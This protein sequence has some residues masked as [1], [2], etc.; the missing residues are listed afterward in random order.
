MLAPRPRVLLLD[1]PFR[2]LDAEVRQKLRADTKRWQRDLGIPTILVTDDR[3]EAL[4]LGD[5]VAIMNGGRFEQIDTPQNVYARPATEFVGRFIDRANVFLTDLSESYGRLVDMRLEMIDHPE[6]ISMFSWEGEQP[7]EEG[8]APIVDCAF[9]GCAVRLEVQPRNGRQ[10]TVDLPKHTAL[11]NDLKP[12]KSITLAM[13]S[14]QVFP[15]HPD[16]R[17]GSRASGLDPE[18]GDGRRRARDPW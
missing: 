11:A 10:V 7:L 1:E 13:D 18:S 15:M 12:G 4:E 9:L 16:S 14:L 5:R 6:D 8:P 2:A 3:R 17:N